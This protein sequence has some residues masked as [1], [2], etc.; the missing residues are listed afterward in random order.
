MT[1]AH[2]GAVDVVHTSKDRVDAPVPTKATVA[3]RYNPILQFVKFMTFYIRLGLM[4][5]KGHEDD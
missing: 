2:R 5:L 4:V 3:N 1:R